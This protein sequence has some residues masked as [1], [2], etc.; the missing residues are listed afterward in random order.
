MQH[1]LH[2]PFFILAKYRQNA[3]LKRNRKSK[4]RFLRFSVARSEEKKGG[5]WGARDSESLV[6]SQIWLNLVRDERHFFHI[7]SPDNYGWI[8]TLATNK[9]SGEKKKKKH[10]SALHTQGQKQKSSLLGLVVAET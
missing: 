10:W 7:V 1:S 5:G 6:Y 2:Q 9:Y 4:K 3:N 8:A